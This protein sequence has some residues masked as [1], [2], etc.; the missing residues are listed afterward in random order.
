MRNFLHSKVAVVAVGSRSDV[1]ADVRSARTI[2][3]GHGD[4]DVSSRGVGGVS[5]IDDK[6]LDVRVGRDD[7][8]GGGG[9]LDGVLDSSVENGINLSN[10][11]GVVDFSVDLG[12][13]GLGELIVGGGLGSSALQGVGVSS[14]LL[15]VCLA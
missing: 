3:T 14:G 6:R 1:G 15:N 10:N 8:G 12:A 5:V 9:G 7:D 11:L 13:L 2:L 4:V